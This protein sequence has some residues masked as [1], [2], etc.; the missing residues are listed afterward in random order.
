ML[1]TCTL[2][3]LTE[4]K[5]VLMECS[6]VHSRWS[7]FC[8]VLFKLNFNGKN[9]TNKTNKQ[10]WRKKGF[11]WNATVHSRWSVW[12]AHR[13]QLRLCSEAKAT[14]KQGKGERTEG[15]DDRMWICKIFSRAS[16]CSIAPPSPCWRSTVFCDDDLLYSPVP[17]RW[18]GRR[19]YKVSVTW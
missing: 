13:P 14:A 11:E 1:S 12:P 2:L 4:K 6:S 5:G 19:S 9:K 15:G 10:G 17:H 3:S 8:F 18:M 7:V 16:P